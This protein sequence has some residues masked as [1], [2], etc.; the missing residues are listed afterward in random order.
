MNFISLVAAHLKCAIIITLLHIH[1]INAFSD[2][3]LMPLNLAV[4]ILS[5]KHVL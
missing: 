5:L 4:I 3:K 1:F 2:I